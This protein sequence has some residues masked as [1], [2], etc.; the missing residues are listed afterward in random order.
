MFHDT[1]NVTFFNE[2]QRGTTHGLATF[3]SLFEKKSWITLL[4]NMPYEPTSHRE[5]IQKDSIV[6]PGSSH[7]LLN[8]VVHHAQNQ[9]TMASLLH[10]DDSNRQCTPFAKEF[11]NA[12]P[13][14]LKGKKISKVTVSSR[15][16]LANVIPGKDMDPSTSHKPSVSHVKIRSCSQSVKRNY[17]SPPRQQRNA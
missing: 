2:L 10:L 3:T 1:K 5:A 4:G 16:P 9:S 13:K 7:A 14:Y 8:C 15:E 12:Q 6:I 17:T 11:R